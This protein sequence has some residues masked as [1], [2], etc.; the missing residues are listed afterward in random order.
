MISRIVAVLVMENSWKKHEK[1]VMQ[2]IKG[3]QQ[4]DDT[5]HPQPRERFV[6]HQGAN[7]RMFCHGLEQN[8]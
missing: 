8:W 5:P 3:Q 7:K 1:G 2:H 6:A 4:A